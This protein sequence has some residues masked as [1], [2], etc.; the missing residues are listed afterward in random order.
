ME[1]RRRIGAYGLCRHDGKVLLVRASELTAFPGVWQIPG[2][3]IEHGEHPESA[4]LREFTEETGLTVEVSGLRTVVAD[5]IRFP[6]R[7]VAMHTD[8]VI[9]ELTS[10]G[11]TLR[12]EPVGTTDRVA[13]AAPEEAGR[14]PL[15]PFTAELLGLPVNPLPERA[16]DPRGR[17]AFAPVRADR[18]QRFA[19]YGLTTDPAGRVL[20]SLIADGYPGAGLWHLP[21]GG[22]DHGEQPVTGLLRELMEEAGQIGRVTALTG[23][24][25]RHN[26]TALGPEGVPIDQ[27]GVRAIYRVEVDVPTEA[28][29]TE[30]AGST[31]RAAWFDVS[32]ARTLPLTDVAAVALDQL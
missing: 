14:I 5:V 20:L 25:H 32:T 26:P 30:Q 29:V 18:W 1:K 2:G 12:E 9:Y 28:A 7:G 8:R 27:H 31:A 24:S 22:T 19:A 4:V 13:W 17:E 3:G 23:L 21:G 6:D 11:G 15:M 16:R 10:T